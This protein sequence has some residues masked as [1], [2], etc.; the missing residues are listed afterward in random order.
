MF[1][2]ICSETCS[3]IHRH[4]A[5]YRTGRAFEQIIGGSQD[6]KDAALDTVAQVRGGDDGV[7]QDAD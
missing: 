2:K 1:R 3:L 6:K 4:R 7:Q 5:E